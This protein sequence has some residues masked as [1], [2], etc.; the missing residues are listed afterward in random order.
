MVFHLLPLLILFP[1]L[2]MVRAPRV[3]IPDAPQL[4]AAFN[5]LAAYVD[6]VAAPAIEPGPGIRVRSG[7]G[8]VHI[9]AIGGDG[10]AGS[11]SDECLPWEAT[12]RNKGDSDA[13]EWVVTFNPGT[14]NQVV[15]GNWNTEF[16][17]PEF[18]TR[19]PTVTVTTSFGRVTGVSLSVDASPPTGDSVAKDTPPTS[20]KII[21]GVIHNHIALMTATA[22]INATGEVVFTESRTPPNPGEEPFSRWYR[23]AITFDS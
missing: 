9:E 19:W 15:P 22:N 3:S 12:I 2:A 23:W 11:G 18:G 10:G 14:V 6:R 1:Y 7:G 8:S 21:L 16:P 20:F 13:P 17:L 4:E 5:A